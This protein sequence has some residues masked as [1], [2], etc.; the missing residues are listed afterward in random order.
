MT[1]IHEPLLEVCNVSVGFSDRSMP[2]ALQDVSFSLQKGEILGIVGE[3]GA[4]KSLLARA[5]IDMLPGDGR[6]VEGQILVNGQAISTMTPEQKRGYRGG[7]VALIGTNAKALLDPVVKV[8]E[9]IA[10]I[11]RAHRGINK[12]DAWQESI[13]L[14]NYSGHAA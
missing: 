9:Q 6:V 2:P 11:L 12:K 3:T 7:E 5:I 1:K 4:G 13:R 10:R 8:G 14:C